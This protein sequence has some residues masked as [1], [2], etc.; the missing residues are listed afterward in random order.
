MLIVVPSLNTISQGSRRPNDGYEMEKGAQKV[1][2]AAIA[3]QNT[4]KPNHII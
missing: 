3:R 4:I 1:I 2:M